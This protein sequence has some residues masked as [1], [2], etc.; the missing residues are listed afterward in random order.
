LNIEKID[1]GV[2]ITLDK[3]VMSALT[4]GIPAP[5]DAETYS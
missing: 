5:L 4:D 1:T 3:F 2:N